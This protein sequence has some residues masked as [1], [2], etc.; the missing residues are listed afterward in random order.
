MGTRG[1]FMDL[2]Q[3]TQALNE[4]DN[5]LTTDDKGCAIF[6]DLAYIIGNRLNTR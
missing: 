5:D 2:Q 3:F 6:Y 4:F 1:E